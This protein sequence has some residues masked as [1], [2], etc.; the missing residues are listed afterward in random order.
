M[1]ST[2]IQ[3]GRGMAKSQQEYSD[4]QPGVIHGSITYFRKQHLAFHV[5][6]RFLK[7]KP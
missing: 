6:C 2:S 4:R 5:S 7:K 1:I 3:P